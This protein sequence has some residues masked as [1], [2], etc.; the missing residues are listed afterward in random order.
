MEKIPLGFC[1]AERVQLNWSTD[2]SIRS[3]QS[4]T[5]LL[6]RKSPPNTPE[7]CDTM[8]ITCRIMSM[9]DLTDPTN[10]DAGTFKFS[11]SGDF[12]QLAQL[13]IVTKNRIFKKFDLDPIYISQSIDE[14]AAVGRAA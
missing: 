2:R 7:N 1:E 3:R 13:K 4:E 12:S 5:A 11:N 14:S 10:S 9:V 8:E 6:S